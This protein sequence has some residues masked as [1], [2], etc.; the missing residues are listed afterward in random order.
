M[1]DLDCERKRIEQAH[2]NRMAKITFEHEQQ[3]REQEFR[4]KT[5]LEAKL[6]ESKIA[7]IEAERIAYTHTTTEKAKIDVRRATAETETAMVCKMK[8]TGLGDT[9]VAVIMRPNTG[10]ELTIPPVLPG[11]YPLPGS[12]YAPI[13]TRHRHKRKMSE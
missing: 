13:L 5:E 3:Q 10:L 6:K 8:E 12:S 11:L 4:H 9:A 2:H 7:A 1:A